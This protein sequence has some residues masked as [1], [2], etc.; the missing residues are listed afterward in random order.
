M[1]EQFALWGASAKTAALPGWLTDCAHASVTVSVRFT[2]D[3]SVTVPV[4]VRRM[5]GDCLMTSTERFDLDEV[6]EL[7]A[8]VLAAA[9]VTV[10]E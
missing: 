3:G 8:A 2:E 9:D 7:V 10:S 4:S 5:V 1:S 6:P